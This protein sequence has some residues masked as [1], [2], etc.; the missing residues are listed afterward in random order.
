MRAGCSVSSLV[1]VFTYA[2]ALR[3]SLPATLVALLVVSTLGGFF[4]NGFEAGDR[5]ARA[6][7]LAVGTRFTSNDFDEIR[8]VFRTGFGSLEPDGIWMVANDAVIAFRSEVSEARLEA[9]FE[10]VPLTGGVNTSLLLYSNTSG[11]LVA[12]RL[13]EGLNEVRVPL[14]YGEL[15]SVAFACG[16]LSSPSELGI[17][18]D[19]RPLCVKFVSAG[20][21]RTNS[22]L[23]ASLR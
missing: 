20:L 10:V 2:G 21:V 9:V 3:A 7:V 15:Q 1:G 18:S 17:N 13:D 11:E 8:S 16:R 12:H 23:G 4:I 19:T 14:P 6:P 22:E 5:D